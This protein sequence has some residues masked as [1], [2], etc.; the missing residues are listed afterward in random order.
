MKEDLMCVVIGNPILE[1][2]RQKIIKMHWIQIA[3]GSRRV[4]EDDKLPPTIWDTLFE[5]NALLVEANSRIIE[6]KE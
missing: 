5:L 6:T 3:L 4:S 2:E 1:F